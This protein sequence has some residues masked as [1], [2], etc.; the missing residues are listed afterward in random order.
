MKYL[1][2]HRK[3]SWAIVIWTALFVLWAFSGMSAV[4]DNCVGMTGS[5]L[6][7][8]NA[9]TGI[10]AGIGL[11]LIGSIW[12]VGFIVLSIVWFMTRPKDA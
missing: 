3:M 4:A 5:D 1:R 11:F 2:G 8:C 10:G 12:F 7:L 6:D 9:G